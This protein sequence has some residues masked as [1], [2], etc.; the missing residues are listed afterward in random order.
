[1]TPHPPL[2]KGYQYLTGPTAPQYLKTGQVAKLM[3]FW[4]FTL[5]GRDFVRKLERCGALTPTPLKHQHG[6]RWATAKV[7]EVW[8]AE[9]K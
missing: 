1:M 6:K 2:P 4:G 9:Q 3:E 7:L 8:R 5:S